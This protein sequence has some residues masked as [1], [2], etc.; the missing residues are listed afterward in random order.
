MRIAAALPL[1]L[2]ALSGCAMRSAAGP[3]ATPAS[4]QAVYATSAGSDITARVPAAT[5]DARGSSAGGA[6]AL[7]FSIAPIASLPGGGAAAPAPGEVEDLGAQ[8]DARVA[9]WEHEIERQRDALGASLAQCRE[10]CIAAS[11]VCTAAYEICRLTGDLANVD[12]RDARCARARGACL[13]AGRRRDGAC[14][15][16]PAR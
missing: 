14:P 10:V 5:E 7:R 16:C 2:L 4:A 3:S 8:R 1:V 13:D 15:A 6:A 9:R 12:A 11:N